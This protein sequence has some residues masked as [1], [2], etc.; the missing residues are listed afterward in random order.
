MME[1]VTK[2]GKHK[3]LK[4]DE[5]EEYEFEFLPANGKMIRAFHLCC[6]CGVLFDPSGA[7]Q[8]RDGE[9]VEKKKIFAEPIR[10]R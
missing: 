4:N 3:G 10:I 7:G 5:G 8:C 1:I 2:Y 6:Y 9:V